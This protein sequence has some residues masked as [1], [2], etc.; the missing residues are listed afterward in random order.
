MKYYVA[1]FMFTE[2]FD[3]VALIRKLRPAWQNGFWNGIGGH[4]EEGERK[5]DAQIREFKEEAGVEYEDWNFLCDIQDPGGILFNV[6]FFWC[7]TDEVYKATTVTDEQ[8]CLHPVDNLPGNVI[9]NL[10]WLIP[11]AIIHDVDI[12]RNDTEQ[13]CP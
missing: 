12:V 5:I 3:R 4:V 7:N 2:E 6:R 1:G 9:S 8:V 13:L 10:K 11:M